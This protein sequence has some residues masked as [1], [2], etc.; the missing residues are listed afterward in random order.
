MA[1]NSINSQMQEE[2]AECAGSSA[3]TCR[4]ITY[5]RG[6]WSIVG[7]RENQRGK[8]LRCRGEKCVFVEEFAGLLL[9][10]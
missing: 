9:G 6:E 3:P 2:S 5:S 4:E 10:I 7:C 1:S 8:W